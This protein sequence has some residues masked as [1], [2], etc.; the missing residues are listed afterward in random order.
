[1]GE[2]GDFGEDKE[3]EPYMNTVMTRENGTTK[4]F[5]IHVKSLYAG[6]GH[7]NRVMNATLGGNMGAYVNTLQGMMLQHQPRERSDSWETLVM[8]FMNSYPHNDM[9]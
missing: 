2:D 4:S 3:L 9:Q 1:M 6:P 8:W 5:G 7:M